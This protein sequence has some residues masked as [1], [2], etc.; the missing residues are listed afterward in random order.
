MC[1]LCCVNMSA[2]H[3]SWHVR[4]V[5]LQADAL[6]APLVPTACALALIPRSGQAHVPAALRPVMMSGGPLREVF[7]ECPEC[8]GFA[9]SSAQLQQV[10]RAAPMLLTQVFS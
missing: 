5:W 4:P 10:G 7:S 2:R 6:L 3:S 1:T 8:M 9:Q